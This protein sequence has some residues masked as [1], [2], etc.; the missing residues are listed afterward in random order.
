MSIV[1]WAEAGR[2]A[3]AAADDPKCSNRH[4]H[5][6]ESPGKEQIEWGPVHG[7]SKQG[8]NKNG[9]ARN[10][11]QAGEKKFHQAESIM[12]RSFL[13]SGLFYMNVHDA[14]FPLGEIRGQLILVPEPS[15]WALLALSA[16]GLLWGMRRRTA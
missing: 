5:G 16:G 1:G 7:H 15:T 9:A 3:N 10:K 2:G 11:Q 12:G 14:Q 6:A 8:E 4:E 13:E